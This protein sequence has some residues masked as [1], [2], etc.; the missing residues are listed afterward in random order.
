MAT[1]FAD[2]LDMPK[3]EVAKAL[4]AFQK[5]QPLGFIKPEQIS[6]AILFLCCSEMTTGVSLPVDGGFLHSSKT[7]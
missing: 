5:S 6:E 4:A 2:N 3:E 1:R 7:P